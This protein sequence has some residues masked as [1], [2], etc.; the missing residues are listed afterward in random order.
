MATAQPARS[1]AAGRRLLLL[2]DNPGE[3]LAR[4]LERAGFHADCAATAGEALVFVEV[5][6]RPAAAVIDL[7]LP[8]ASGGLV[9]WRLRHKYGRDVPVAVVTGVADPLDHPDLRR[10]PPDRLFVKPVD[11]AHVVAWLR[12]VT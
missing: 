2:E 1:P 5:S 8:D 6:P 10:D 4:A 11:M 12:N 7:N 9:L 3:S